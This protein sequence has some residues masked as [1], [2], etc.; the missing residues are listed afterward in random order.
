MSLFLCGARLR[1][2]ENQNLLKPKFGVR[3]DGGGVQR[4]GFKSSAS[5][6]IVNTN[7]G[8]DGS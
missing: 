1:D 6:G 2:S 7:A 4:G 5:A 8:S 3:R